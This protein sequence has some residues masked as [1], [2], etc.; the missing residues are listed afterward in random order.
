MLAGGL[1]LYNSRYP[2]FA[3]SEHDGQRKHVGGQRRWNRSR[4]FVEDAVEVSA[5]HSLH[6]DSRRCCGG[7][8]GAHR[9]ADLSCGSRVGTYDPIGH[10]YDLQ[11]FGHRWH[12]QIF[13]VLELD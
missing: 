9:N 12:D 1:K 10:P 3:A 2:F 13:L 8:S 4:C 6:H 11:S 5:P 7:N